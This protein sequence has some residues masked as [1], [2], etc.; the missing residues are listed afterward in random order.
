MGI[1]SRKIDREYAKIIRIGM[2]LAFLV[3]FIVLSALIFIPIFFL[4]SRSVFYIGLG[5][6]GAILLILYPLFAL[7]LVPKYVESFNLQLEDDG[8]HIV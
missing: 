5:L 3:L 2:A 8:I 6:L 1:M 4:G 7:T